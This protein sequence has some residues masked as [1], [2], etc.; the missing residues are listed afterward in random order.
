MCAAAYHGIGDPGWFE[1]SLALG[2]LLA[3]QG[4][5]SYLHVGIR[6][7]G[8]TFKAHAWVE[9]GGATLIEPEMQ[10]RH[11]AAFGAVLML[12]PREPR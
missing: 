11:F 2:W 6:K 7:D 4:I 1:S 12:L 8:E 10:H 3:R 5:A 9:C